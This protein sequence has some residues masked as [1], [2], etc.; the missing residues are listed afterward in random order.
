MSDL[1]A[2]FTNNLS[3]LILACGFVLAAIIGSWTFYSVRSFDNALQVTGSARSSITSDTVK[4]T[5]QFTRTVGSDQLKDG[6]DQ[7]RKD[8][9]AVAAFLKTN[10][11]DEKNATVS[12]V[13]MDMDYSTN[14]GMPRRQILRQNVEIRSTDV[15]GITK[16]AK[17]VDALISKGVLFSTQSLEY[18]YSKLPDLR[19]ELLTDAMKD[20]RARATNIA[21]SDG[22]G[23]GSLKSAS[24]GVVQVLA[25]GSTSVE[26]YGAY[27]TSSIDKEVMV[28]VRATFTLR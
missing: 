16:V 6:Y 19:V 26:D 15:A 25:P 17:N 18:G 1:R 23:V 13:F 7:M 10:A 11:I 21:G 20:A 22:H 9:A 12:P 4:W 24:I 2:A 28:T 8:A 27:D 14:D 5:A 3:A